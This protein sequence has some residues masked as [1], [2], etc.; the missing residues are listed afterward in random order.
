MSLLFSVVMPVY[1]AEGYIGK[2]LASLEAQ[3]CR[4]FEVVIVDDGS[5]DGTP[6]LLDAYAARHEKVGVIHQENAGPML[7]RRAGVS[8]ARGEYVLFLDSD[9]EFVPEAL[10]VIERQI[11]RT[12]ADI[13]M[14]SFLREDGTGMARV[15]S[16][17]G[18]SYFDH[19]NYMKVKE[20]VCA[21]QSSNLWSKSIK[22]TL[23]DHSDYS[24]YK[25]MKHGED[26]FQLFPLVDAAASFSFI[27]NQL[28]VYNQGDQSG[29]SAYCTT[30][31][32]DLRTV[33]K[34]LWDY[35]DKWGGGC[36]NAAARGELLNYIY[37]LKISEL[38]SAPKVEKD[39]NFREICEAMQAEGVFG[40]CLH[41]D[42]RFDNRLIACAMKRRCRWLARLVVLAVEAIKR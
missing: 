18:G 36:P 31:L 21:G 28:Y 5:T 2:A 33:C 19:A 8:A 23:F 32:S 42:L 26:W 30:Q 17:E 3:T 11:E 25:G 6:G 24:P 14:F 27:P 7:A 16:D 15:A 38:S 12:R 10:D 20:T 4:N 9:D 41:A 29:T 22:R 40:R 1:N 13:V 37:L 39:A 35:A 34:R